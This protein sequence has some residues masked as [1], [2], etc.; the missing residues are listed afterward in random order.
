[1]CTQNPVESDAA[2][3]ILTSFAQYFGN[4]YVRQGVS[5]CKALSPSLNTANFVAMIKR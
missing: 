3:M 4:M 2:G 5:M 1:M